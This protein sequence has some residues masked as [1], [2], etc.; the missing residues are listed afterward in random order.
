M[1]LLDGCSALVTGASA[2]I[3]REFARQ[4]AGRAST[5]VLV[6]R[7]EERLRELRD[8]LVRGNPSLRVEVRRTDLSRRDEVDELVAWLSGQ[9]FAI[10]LLVNNA[11][12]GDRGT[13]ATANPERVDAMLKVNM[14]ALTR[15]TR[16][17]LPAMID[18]GRGGI[19]NVSSSAGF[20]SIPNFAVYAATK[21]YATSFSKALRVELLGSGVHVSALCPG[22]VR[23]EFRQVARRKPAGPEEP[24][25]GIAYVAVEKVVADGLAGIEANRPEVIPGAVMKLGMFLVR[26]IPPPVLQLVRRFSTKSAR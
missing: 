10:D 12:L 6:A 26:T 11:G 2:G 19:L 14:V 9:N 25:R 8:E 24:E 20:L 13:F 16:A 17:L 21:A 23:T 15:L 4:L 1:K 22:P 18:R 3:G 7:R 5:L